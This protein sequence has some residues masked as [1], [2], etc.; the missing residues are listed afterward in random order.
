MKLREKS[1]VLRRCQKISSDGADATVDGTL[2][3]NRAAE[4]VKACRQR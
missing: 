1:S 4:M 2:F 3:H